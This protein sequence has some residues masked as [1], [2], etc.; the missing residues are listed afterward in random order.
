LPA[1]PISAA[2]ASGI[3]FVADGSAG[4]QVINYLPF[5]NRGQ[6]PTVTI[7]TSAVDVDP[8]TNGVQVIQGSSIPILANV[9]DDVQVRNVELLVNGEVVRNDVSFPFD[10]SAIALSDDPSAPVTTVQVRATDTGG[11]V[12]LSNVLVVDLVPDTFAP[13]IVSIDLADGAKRAQGH[14]TLRIRFSESLDAAGVAASDFTLVEAGPGGLFGDGNDVVVATEFQLRSEDQLVQLTTDPLPVGFY[15][16]QI[17]ETGLTDR[18]GNAL[19]DGTFTSGFEVVEAIPILIN[20]NAGFGAPRSYSESGLSIV[21]RQDHLHMSSNL[22]NHDGCC[23]TPYQFTFG[24]APFT[25]VSLDVLNNFGS[26]SFTSSSGAV[27]A[28]G[29]PGT[30]TFDPAGWTNITSFNWDQP[31]GQATIDNL[32]ILTSPVSAPVTGPGGSGPNDTTLTLDNMLRGLAHDA[33]DLWAGVLG[34]AGE[35]PMAEVV[36]ANLPDGQLATM[37]FVP[38]EIGEPATALIT[39]DGDAN[40]VGWFIDPTPWDH[41]EFAATDGATELSAIATSS[42]AGRYDLFTV[43]LHEA[44]HALGFA[45][46]AGDDLMAESLVPGVRRLPTISS[47]S[48]ESLPFDTDPNAPQSFVLVAALHASQAAARTEAAVGMAH[49]GLSSEFASF[50]FVSDSHRE[51]STGKAARALQSNAPAKDWSLWSFIGDDNQKRFDDDM[52]D[53]ATDRVGEPMASPTENVHELLFGECIRD[54][55]RPKFETV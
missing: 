7:S 26:G 46:T 29:G 51:S 44:G 38:G 1:E 50:D 55:L 41:S 5:D 37:Q 49:S 53:L 40:G 27:V 47:G 32:Q 4:L 6:A 19:G 15:Q 54:L 9:L 14:R 17:D 11:N 2:I 21:S 3:A 33:M 34:I 35:H 24:G 20:F 10:F 31:L 18:A 13:T 36:V 16:L 30:I 22:M 12:A 45:H 42:A 28:I 8:A 48:A 52:I 25:V 39:V 43:L 23:S